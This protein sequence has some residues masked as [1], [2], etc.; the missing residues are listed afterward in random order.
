MP[1]SQ[2]SLSKITPLLFCLNPYLLH[3][4]SKDDLYPTFARSPSS[5]ISFSG[6]SALKH[7]FHICSIHGC[8]YPWCLAKGLIQNRCPVNICCMDEWSTGFAIFL[9]CCRWSS[10]F[11]SVI[12][13]F[14]SR[15][16]RTCCFSNWGD[17]AQLSVQKKQD[18]VSLSRCG[19]FD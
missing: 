12:C 17:L 18:R 6:F 11:G 3:F 15:C 7:E 16:G 4:S 14:I 19:S 5:L 10:M 9:E 8:R 13:D 2:S 1:P